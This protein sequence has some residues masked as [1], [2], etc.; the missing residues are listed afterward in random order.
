METIMLDVLMSNDSKPGLTACSNKGFHITFPNGWT[1]SVQWGPG[2]YCEK[3]WDK[4]NAPE[5]T[6]QGSLVMYRSEDAEVAAWRYENGKRTWHNFGY[7]TVSGY[8]SP[9]EVVAFM[10]QVAEGRDLNTTSPWDLLDDDDTD[11]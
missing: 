2:N 7:D 4:P 5:R 1:V 8:L 9:L 10:A 3:K 6:T 11:E